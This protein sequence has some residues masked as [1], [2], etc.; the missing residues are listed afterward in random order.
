LIRS[1]GA[2]RNHY[3]PRSGLVAGGTLHA[4]ADA[5]DQ[6]GPSAFGL[7]L[8][9]CT[10]GAQTQQVLYEA[11]QSIRS[12]DGGADPG[13]AGLRAYV[14]AAVHNKAVAAIRRDRGAGQ[15]QVLA[16]HFPA[17]CAIDGDRAFG[18]ACP[19]QVRT[20]VRRLPGL[21]RQALELAYF[22][23]LSCSGVAGRLG[24]PPGATKACLRDGMIRLRQELDCPSCAGGL[25]RCDRGG[26]VRGLRPAGP[27]GLRRRPPDRA[28][29]LR[30]WPGH[31]DGGRR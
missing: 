1:K 4:C 13:R 25:A 15:Q 11:F 17:E 2:R 21:Q 26:P 24:I 10:T 30:R 8:S 12:A 5:F 22:Q 19:Q 23:A 14:F 7:A 20:A 31:G 16:W 6:H 27:G 29:C 18:A 28:R 3:E 9:L